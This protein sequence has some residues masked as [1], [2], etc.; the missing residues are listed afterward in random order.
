MVYPAN[1]GV[2]LIKTETILNRTAATSDTVS[3]VEVIGLY[4]PDG[5]SIDLW[6]YWVQ[7]PRCFWKA[8]R[9]FRPDE[10]GY[11]KAYT[12]M[13]IHAMACGRAVRQNTSKRKRAK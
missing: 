13:R 7:C 6:A 12:T 5:K 2:S 3:P 11:Q 4:L 8:P 9:F 10:D 1:H